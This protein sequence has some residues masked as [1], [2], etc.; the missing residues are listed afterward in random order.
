MRKS[1]DTAGALALIV[2]VFIAFFVLVAVAAC[3]DTGG[4]TTYYPRDTSHGYYDTHHHYHYY[5]RYHGG[6]KVRPAPR[7]NFKPKAPS[8][9]KSTR[10]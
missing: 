5:P 1:P 7:P 8:F 9:R 6:V 10:R 3:N 4:G 2:G